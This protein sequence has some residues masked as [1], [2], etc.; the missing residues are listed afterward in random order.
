MV[1]PPPAITNIALGKSVT[2]SV[3]KLY[4]GKL[5]Q[6]TDGIIDARNDA[7][8]EMRKG[9]Q[10]V[11]IDLE[12]EYPLAMIRVWHD[13]RHIQKFHD[14]IIQT[15]TDA[16]FQ[17]NAFTLFNNDSDNS[18]KQGVGTASEYPETSKGLTVPANGVK[19]R[20]VRCYSKGSNLSA[21]NAYQEIEVFT[22]LPGNSNTPE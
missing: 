21:Y 8:L 17:T 5:Q 2:S 7:V 22:W 20:Y 6:I 18:S 10:W 1:L 9:T 14:V 4:N 13:F 3:D 12:N 11:Q 15:A 16:N 19:A